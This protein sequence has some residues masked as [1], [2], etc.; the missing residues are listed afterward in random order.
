[1]ALDGDHNPAPLDRPHRGLSAKDDR[2]LAALLVADSMK[3]AAE[4]AGIPLRTA[5]RRMSRGEFRAELTY[6]RSELL[7]AA[8]RRLAAEAVASIDAMCRLRDD[9]EADRPTRLRAATELLKFALKS[10]DVLE[11]ASVLA[12]LQ[13]HMD[14]LERQRRASP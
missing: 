14:E 1:M 11:T 4:A 10:N 6:R 2:L 7:R 13:E 9:A 3:A 8:A 12:W 5:W